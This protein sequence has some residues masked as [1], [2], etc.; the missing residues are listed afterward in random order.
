M[1]Q[2]LELGL[3][4]TDVGEA[5]KDFQD[6]YCIQELSSSSE[7][8]QLLMILCISNSI[9]KVK[10]FSQKLRECAFLNIKFLKAHRVKIPNC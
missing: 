10:C 6:S 3:H 9:L 5:L 2:I 4:L 8:I 1:D 7:E